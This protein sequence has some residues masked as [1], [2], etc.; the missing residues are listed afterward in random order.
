MSWELL[1]EYKASLCPAR[2]A[3]PN[4]RRAEEDF[5]PAYT[6]A[7]NSLL[8]FGIVDFTS[9]NL[10][11]GVEQYQVRRSIERAIRQFDP[12]LAPLPVSL[13]EPDPRRPVL[14]FPIQ[15][16]LRIRPAHE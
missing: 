8:S 4:T 10:K 2:S 1:R 13:E 16:F 6:E 7:T 3:L 12:R 5:D 11:S 9:Y 14:Q 15:P